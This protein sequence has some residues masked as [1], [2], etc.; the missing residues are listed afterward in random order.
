MSE[1]AIETNAVETQEPDDLDG[2]LSEYDEAF[3]HPGQESAPEPEDSSLDQ[4]TSDSRI[5]ALYDWALIKEYE[6]KQAA[7]REALE[8]SANTLLESLDNPNI[9]LKMA[10][11]VLLSEYITSDSFRD[12]Y[13]NRAENPQAWESAL[14]RVE[15][16][17]REDLKSD[18]DVTATADRQAVEAMIRGASSR[19]TSSEGPDFHNMSNADFEKYKMSLLRR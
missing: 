3:N 14:N 17:W 16:S 15:R 13:E 2:L 10:K 18:V 5:D 4:D 6:I 11:S 8:Q 19:A 7:D 9:S 12:A 1:E